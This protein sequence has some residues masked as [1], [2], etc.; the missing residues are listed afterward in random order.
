[1]KTRN[2]SANRPTRQPARLNRAPIGSAASASRPNGV[3]AAARSTVP[4]SRTISSGPGPPSAEHVLV[5]P[6][7]PGVVAGQQLEP[8]RRARL[9][10]RGEPRELAGLPGADPNAD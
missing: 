7:G 2:T 10:E 8:D 9:V 6:D 4:P 5:E 1:M 3:S